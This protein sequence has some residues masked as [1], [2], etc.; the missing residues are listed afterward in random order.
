MAKPRKKYNKMK[1][2]TRVADHLIRNKVICYTDDLAGCIVVDLKSNRVVPPESKEGKQVIAALSRPHVWSCFIAAFG[3]SLDQ[4]MKSEQIITSSRYYQADL[5]PTFEEYHTK[6]IKSVP[7]HHRC[8][9]GWI[10]SPEARD[11]TEKEAADIFEALGVWE[12]ATDPV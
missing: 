8:G 7:E 6:L 5:A 3:R 9:V 4:Y 10:A 11:F 12:D 1:Q 2:L